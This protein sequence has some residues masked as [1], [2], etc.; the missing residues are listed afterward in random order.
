MSQNFDQ[1]QAMLDNYINTTI[2]SNITL[3][4]YDCTNH[5]LYY[6]TSDG[7]QKTSSDKMF[8]SSIHI[9][10]DPS[11]NHCTGKNSTYYCSTLEELS[12]ILLFT[13]EHPEFFNQNTDNEDDVYTNCTLTP[14]HHINANALVTPD[15]FN[16]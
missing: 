10:Y 7:I 16:D 14:L 15:D 1:L 3:S 8:L 13:V 4:V 5:S 11:P 6:L 2:L 12:D 9:V